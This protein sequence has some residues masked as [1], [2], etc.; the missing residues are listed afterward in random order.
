MVSEFQLAQLV[1]AIKQSS[2][3][4]GATKLVTIDGPAG[5]GKTT[6]ANQLFD[7]LEDCQVIHLDDIYEGWNQDLISDLPQKI[8]TWL[9]DKFKAGLPG[10]YEKFNWTTK[11]Y[12]QV[13]QV[14]NSGIVIIEGVGASNPRI[15]QFS[16]IN[17][18]IEADKS[19][20]LDRLIAR[21]GEKYR[22]ELTTWLRH[23]SEYFG[24]LPIK[25]LAHFQIQTD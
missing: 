20:R 8:E 22:A 7:C 4:C 12:D 18:W 14:A 24:S 13:I 16:A 23:E 3:L 6:L 10:E 19:V 1:N 15:G 17:I 5:S 25:N 11:Q 2:K 21:D 9:L